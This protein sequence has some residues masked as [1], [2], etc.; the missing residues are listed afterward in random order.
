MACGCAQRGA[1][2]AFT[3]T[4]GTIFRLE[5]RSGYFWSAATTAYYTAA[6]KAS[7]AHDLPCPIEEVGGVATASDRARDLLSVGMPAASET[8]VT[9][10]G[11]IVA[12][13]LD[14]G[15][16]FVRVRKSDHGRLIHYL[17][18]DFRIVLVSRASTWAITP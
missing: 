15:P 6:L 3:A 9:G 17:D 18:Y 2:D 12:Y 7:A 4:D 14:T 8:T 1:Y 11:G 5:N 13:R 10:C 16:Q